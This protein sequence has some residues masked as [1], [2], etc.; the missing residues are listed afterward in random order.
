MIASNQ[1]TCFPPD[2][3]VAVSSRSDG[4]ML[5][6][7]RGVHHP[8]VVASRRSF[9]QKNGI[10]YDDV[11]YQRIVYGEKRRYDCMAE[12]DCGM[13][14]AYTSEL[15][16]D[17]L[18]TKERGVALFLPVS[19]CIA[20]VLYDPVAKHLAMLHL[21]RHSTIAGLMRRGI[22]A[23]LQADSR[24]EDI[25]VWMSPS[26][27]AE[28]YVMQYFDQANKSDWRDFYRQSPEGI[29]L[30]MQ[31]YNA[32]VCRR[33]GIPAANIHCSPINTM[34][35]PDYFSHACGE[36]SGRI[37]VVAMML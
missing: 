1:P 3:L 17:G 29:H 24:P 14:T 7:P 22:A 4:T 31:G 2:V 10:V 6:R 35:N 25:V 34:T 21:G 13:T 30:D 9:C 8:E 33:A 15:M 18:F 23:F 19:D 28:T 11:V 32:A 20:A 36:R 12:V 27:Q 26:A 16:A 37:A 5:D